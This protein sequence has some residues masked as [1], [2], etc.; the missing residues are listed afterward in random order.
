MLAR[1]LCLLIR[2]NRV[3]LNKEDV[4]K[5]CLFVSGLCKE[6]GCTEPAELCRK[7]AE[8]VVNSEEEYLE[9]CRK[10]MHACG[11]SRRPTRT[12]EEKKTMYVA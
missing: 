7:A 1:E 2:R 6:A 10:A 12:R 4:K 9:L 11:E 8:A 3:V 5:C